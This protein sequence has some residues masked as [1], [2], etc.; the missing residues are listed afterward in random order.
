LILGSI[1]LRYINEKEINLSFYPE[2]KFPKTGTPVFNGNWEQ[3]D[4]SDPRYNYHDGLQNTQKFPESSV[5]NLFSTKEAAQARSLQIGCGGYH[6]VTIDGEIF[7]K[8]CET[9]EYYSVRIEQL[10]SALNFTYIG[11]YRVLTWDKPYLDV[12]VCNGWI[13]D[14]ANSLNIGSPLNGDIS[15]DFRY[16]IDGKTWSL[17][18]NVGSVKN[19]LTGQGAEIFPINL[20]PQNK[21]YPEFRFTS[22][23]VNDNGTLIYNTDEPIDPNVVIVDF[24]LDLEYGDPIEVKIVAPAPV[25]SNEVSTRPVIFSDCKFTFNPYAV[26]KALNLYQDLSLIVNK[27]FGL[28]SNYYSVQPQGRGKDVILKEYTL[29]NVVAEKCVKILVPQNQFPDNKINFDPFGLQFEEPFEIQIDKRYF[30][31]IFGKGSQPRKRDILY[32]PI[33]NRIYEINST[34]L[35]RD[36]MNSPVYFK[37]ELRKYSPKSNT[38]FLD[39]EYKEQLDGIALTT[40]ELFGEE[41]KAEEEKYSKPQQFA[42]T[43]TQLIQDPIR[44]YIYTGLPIIGYDLN[45]N[46]T[47]VLNNYYDLS[48]AFDEVSE[49]QQ[50]QQRYRNAI[51][52]KVLPLLTSTGELS[53]TCWFNL[54]DFY[55]P[56]KLVPKPFS[57]I[58]IT[59]ES[60]DSNYIIFSSYPAK[61]KLQ[62]WASYA[63]NPEGY[64]SIQ[65][66]FNH[67]GG[68][69]VEEVIDEYRFKI[70]NLNT[71]FSE[72]TIVWKMQKAQ[73]RNLISGLYEEF[74]ETYGFRVDLVHSGVTDSDGN[75]FIQQGSFIVRINNDIINSKLQF[76][77]VDG[78]WY[79]FVV[80]VSNVYKQIS[81]NAWGLTYDPTNPSDQSSNLQKLHEDIRFFDTVKVFSA[82]A[83]EET[84]PNNIFYG[85]DNNSYKIFTGPAF[86]SNVRLFKNMIDIDNQSIVLNQNIVRDN[87]L[88]YII[89]NAKPLLNTPKFAR[90][91]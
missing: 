14:A 68:Y 26:N 82:P 5:G 37:V 3:Y 78:D 69:T 27:V 61:H 19:G 8:P 4:L 64:V 70:K 25:C 34:Y 67:S 77:P 1:L 45:N 40:P 36:F 9:A 86:L 56:A 63:S 29:F 88:A 49:F 23:L 47:I 32:F 28:E 31:S 84:D 20:N 75:L 62:V 18:S 58:N 85:T 51:R 53:F 81:I 55:D 57:V 91:R 52:Y 42:T 54:R 35:F 72:G 44:S 33:S 74:Y 24:Q 79:G 80:N 11:S 12:E 39:P 71:T 7:Y 2:N 30:E 76:T 38:Y 22:V 17:W 60:Y 90:N 65:G 6:S 21:F 46:W 66:D 48:A 43:I 87:Q 73:A 89:D 10:D 50:E 13:I 41:V 59:L 16:S 83:D 15:I